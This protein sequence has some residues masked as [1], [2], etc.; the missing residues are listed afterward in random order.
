MAHAELSVRAVTVGSFPGLFLGCWE[1]RNGKAFNR[2]TVM[3]QCLRFHL[4]ANSHFWCLFACWHV[5]E[6]QPNLNIGAVPTG[7]MD[8][9]LNR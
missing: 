1:H 7:L 2:K 3:S 5:A 6:T 9:G 8:V 4:K